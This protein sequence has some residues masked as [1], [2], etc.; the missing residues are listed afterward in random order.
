MGS[1]SCTDL[2]VKLKREKQ[3]EI[4]RLIRKRSKSSSGRFYYPEKVP[5]TRTSVA[6][7]DSVLHP[8]ISLLKKTETYPPL[9]LGH[10]LNNS[11]QTSDF[12]QVKLFLEPLM[13]KTIDIS[14]EGSRKSKSE[15]V[16][17]GK[18]VSGWI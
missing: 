7:L 4:A 18:V 12:G 14:L 16:K 1:T 11:P 6:K 5:R 15:T 9:M 17:G 3:S 10:N 13:S 2:P 8:D